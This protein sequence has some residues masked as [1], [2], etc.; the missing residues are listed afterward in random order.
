MFL[1]KWG[2]V[3]IELGLTI[4]SSKPFCLANIL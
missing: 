2:K 4:I 1:V 3:N